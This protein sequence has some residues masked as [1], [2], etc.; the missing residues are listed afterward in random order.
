METDNEM[1]ATRL[2]HDSLEREI[3][4][5]EKSLRTKMEWMR[6]SF[7]EAERALDSGRTPNSCGI[8]QHHG[9]EIDMAVARLDQAKQTL[10][11]LKAAATYDRNH[12]QKE[13]Q[14][15]QHSAIGRRPAK[16]AVEAWAAAGLKKLAGLDSDGAQDLNGEGFNKHDTEIGHSLARQAGNMTTKQWA[17]AVRIAH[18][19]RRQIGEAPKLETSQ[20]GGR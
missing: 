19:Y 14:Q 7:A 1:T 18:K 4:Q 16:D 6:G 2:A 17:I 15:I 11:Q 5:I 3:K 8:I 13:P 20:P 10:G 9:M 12:A